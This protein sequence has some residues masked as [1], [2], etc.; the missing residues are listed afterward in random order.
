MDYPLKEISS[1]EVSSVFSAGGVGNCDVS[2]TIFEHKNI[3]ASLVVGCVMV[4]D[5][6]EYLRGL[7]DL[8]EKYGVRKVYTVAGMKNIPCNDVFFPAM[9]LDEGAIEE[10]SEYSKGRYAK[11]Q[12]CAV[13]YMKLFFCE[14]YFLGERSV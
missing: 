2:F 13:K 6:D 11:R 9:D 3:T 7:E 5:K 10:L 1:C 4:L 14:G 12:T 8:Y